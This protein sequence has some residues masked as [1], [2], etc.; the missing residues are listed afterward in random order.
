M[1]PNDY[2]DIT[3]ELLERAIDRIYPSTFIKEISFGYGV[4]ER[5]VQEQ[6]HVRRMTP[7]E[8]AVITAI[9]YQIELIK[10]TDISKQE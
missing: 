3:I 7:E 6:T 1:E 8:T 2:R 9:L 5:G 4:M 10:E